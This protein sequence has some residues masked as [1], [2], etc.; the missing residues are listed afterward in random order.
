MDCRQSNTPCTPCN[1]QTKNRRETYTAHA[2]HQPPSITKKILISGESTPYFHSSTSLF[3]LPTP[4]NPSHT[5]LRRIQLSHQNDPPRLNCPNNKRPLPLLRPL[6]SRPLQLP[7]LPLFPRMHHPHAEDLAT[8]IY[9]CSG[10]SSG[11]IKASTTALPRRA[12]V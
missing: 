11:S 5:K 7:L 12:R 3:H 10:S 9:N 2:I 4:I 6:L 8:K 1:L